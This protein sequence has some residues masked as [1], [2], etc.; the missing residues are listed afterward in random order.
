MEE[1]IIEK[2][3]DPKMARA[4]EGSGPSFPYNFVHVFA[5]ES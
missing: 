4:Q 2:K 1:I 5:Y 3:V